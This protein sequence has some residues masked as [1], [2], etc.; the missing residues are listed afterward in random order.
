MLTGDGDVLALRVVGTNLFG[1]SPRFGL[2]LHELENLSG[3]LTVGNIKVIYGNAEVPVFE[4]FL[5]GNGSGNRHGYTV[6][7]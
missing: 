6:R 2:E 1:P 3:S 4:Y 5:L 7:K